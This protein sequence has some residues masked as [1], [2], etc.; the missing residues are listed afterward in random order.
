MTMYSDSNVSTKYLDPQI[1]TPN[2]R[3]TFQLDASESAYLPNMRLLNLGANS[4]TGGNQ[5]NGLTG[6][7]GLI[8]NI[9]LMDGKTV[10]C[11][12]NEAQFH[13]AFKNVNETNERNQSVMS[14]QQCTTLGLTVNGA[15][16]KI[17]RMAKVLGTNTTV[18]TTESGSIELKTILPMLSA[19]SHLPTAIFTNLNLQIEYYVGP[20]IIDDTS[21]LVDTI[22]PILAVDVID[23]PVIVDNLNARLKSASWLEVEHDL[24]VIPAVADAAAADNGVVQ[25]VNVQLNGFNNK[26]LERLL[27]T[28]EAGA[29]AVQNGAQV[30]GFGIFGSQSCFR[31]KLQFR[32]N[33]RNLLPRQ[34]IVGNNERLAH[35]VDHWGDCTAYIGSNQYGTDPSPVLTDGLN[36]LGMVDFMGTYIGEYINN[37]QIRYERTA[38]QDTGPRRSTSQALTAHVYGEVRKM[39]QVGGPTGYRISYQQ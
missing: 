37:L 1:Y 30:K 28:K 4:P 6:A 29:A 21:I 36:F 23:N 20:Q 11:S 33:G 5:Y 19:V 10:L 38:L 12:A 17:T 35:I 2:A 15:D 3:T 32:V 25:P 9:R 13:T 31:Q 7:L 39:L 24:F 34:G 18:E 14:Q 26:R 16:N 8:K 22:R 27:I